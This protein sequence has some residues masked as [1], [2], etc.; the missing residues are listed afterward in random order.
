MTTITRKIKSIDSIDSVLE[1][2][3][4]ELAEVKEKEYPL[5]LKVM[6]F[7]ESKTLQQLGV[8]F[9]IWIK[10]I[11]H[12]KGIGEDLVHAELKQ[13]FLARIYVTDSENPPNESQAMWVELLYNYQIAGDMGKLERHAKRISLSWATVD[14]M[15]RYMSAIQ[16]SYTDKGIYLTPPN[17]R[18]RIRQEMI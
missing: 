5:I 14:Q 4:S 3:C 17:P 6:N 16:N 12:A 10:E 7:K 2:V 15:S 8:T 11:S 1:S 13:E 18:Y 9:G